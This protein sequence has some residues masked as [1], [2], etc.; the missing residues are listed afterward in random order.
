MPEKDLGFEYQ[1]TKEGCVFFTHNGRKAGSISGKAGAKFI[2]KL[3]SS[4]FVEQQ[5]MMAKATGH[6]KHGNER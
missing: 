4:G 6:Y 2:V 3:E 1:I 5:L